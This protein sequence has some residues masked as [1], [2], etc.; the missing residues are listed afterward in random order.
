M[1]LTSGSR[2]T[3]HQ[4]TE[5]PMPKD[6]INRVTQMG[7]EQKMP[8]T[9]TIS[10][11]HGREIV[12]SLEEMQ[13]DDSSNSLDSY[14]ASDKDNVT[15]EY[16]SDGEESIPNQD[17]MEEAEHPLPVV[18]PI[19]EQDEP[20][21]EAPE[22]FPVPAEDDNVDQ[23]EP[24][25]ENDHMS[26]NNESTG[27]GD[28]NNESN[29]SESTGVGDNDDEKSVNLETVVDDMDDEEVGP[30]LEEMFKEAEEQG[31]QAATSGTETRS[32]RE[33]KP[34]QFPEFQYL[35]DLV[36]SMPTTDA[37]CFMMSPFMDHV[38]TLVTEQMSAKKC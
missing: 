2:I 5:L 11:R 25:L 14:S 1:S 36:A 22:M 4:W 38:T 10:N 27:V 19:N 9:I 30:T 20:M 37:F 32:K 28:N 12:D 35:C 18:D 16:D 15:L 13:D 3:R 34:L 31:K 8:T 24:L 29:D 21:P 33:R 6:V 17:D 26:I 7:R 23:N